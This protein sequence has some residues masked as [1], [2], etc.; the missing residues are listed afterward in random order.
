[1]FDTNYFFLTSL[2]YQ[3]VRK[4]N[5]NN[6]LNAD[7][8]EFCQKY[9]LALNR[10]SVVI[11]AFSWI[12]NNIQILI[13]RHIYRKN[14]MLDLTEQELADF[15]INYPLLNQELVTEVN[16]LEASTREK[17]NYLTNS[18]RLELLNMDI[19]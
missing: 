5:H 3:Y 2:V 11:Y 7:Y 6:L 4:M 13:Y 19:Y 15:A 9:N 10:T 12:E 16:I 18:Q 8:L 14:C 17:L 1:M